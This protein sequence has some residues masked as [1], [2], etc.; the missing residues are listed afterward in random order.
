MFNAVGVGTPTTS[1]RDGD[2]QTWV[3]PDGAIVRL[4]KGRIGTSDRAIAF[5]PDGQHL[6]VAS[7]I[8]VWLYDAVTSRAL[9]LLSTANPVLSVS[10]S[11]DGATL[12]SGG[13][14][15]TVK[16]WNVA[17]QQNIT[18]LW[19]R[20][21][22]LSVSF[23]PD[24]VT[25]ASGAGDGTVELWDVATQQNIATLKHTGPVTSVS[26]SSNETTLASGSNDGTVK[27]WD[28]ATQQNIATLKHTGA[29]HFRVI[30]IRRGNPRF[31]GGAR[32]QTMGHCDRTH[33]HHTEA[34]KWS[35]CIVV[36]T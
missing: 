36:F 2:Y 22:I 26:F 15:S 30:F 19:S 9:T 7:G 28:V 18:T 16:L 27:L 11:P 12:V 33:Y 13:V 4:G 31:G 20:G 25:L 35:H 14:D 21:S 3:L 10:F 32:S 34:R 29:G 1:S 8:G 17:T 6:A 24:G 5:S 23:S